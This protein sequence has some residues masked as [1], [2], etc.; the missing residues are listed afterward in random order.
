MIIKSTTK[1]VLLDGEYYG[2]WSDDNVCIPFANMDIYIYILVD[3]T[4]PHH[5]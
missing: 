5:D 3:C 4:A 2:F 1:L